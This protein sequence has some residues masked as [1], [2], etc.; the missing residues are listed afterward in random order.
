MYTSKAKK[1]SA[2]SDEVDQKITS[3]EVGHVAR[4]LY[5]EDLVVTHLDRALC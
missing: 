5:H 4:G 1:A 3:T 2:F